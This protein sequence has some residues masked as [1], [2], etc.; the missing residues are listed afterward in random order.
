MNT[1]DL[2]IEV[3]ETLLEPEHKAFQRNVESLVIR[4]TDDPSVLAFMYNGVVFNAAT[5]KRP[6]RNAISLSLHLTDEMKDNVHMLKLA[7]RDAQTVWQA[8]LPLVEAHGPQNGLP[9]N[10]KAILRSKFSPRTT[11]F[12]EIIKDTTELF[13]KNWMD[14]SNQL[15]YLISLRI[16]I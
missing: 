7:T 14:A 13:L 2:G 11:P 1:F 9:E 5:A 8:L 3:K 4:N 6:I 10:L 12:E 15:A 16:V